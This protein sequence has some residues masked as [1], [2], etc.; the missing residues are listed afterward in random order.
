MRRVGFVPT[1]TVFERAKTIH[2]LE[3]AATA[4]GLRKIA[5]YKMKDLRLRIIGKFSKL[6]F[7]HSGL[8]NQ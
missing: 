8:N 7:F 5:S 2:A 6:T 1:T 4:V 3:L